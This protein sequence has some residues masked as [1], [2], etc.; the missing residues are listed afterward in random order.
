MDE[1]KCFKYFKHKK[2]W[3]KKLFW[4]NISTAEFYTQNKTKMFTL[5][6]F[7]AVKVGGKSFPSSQA[8]LFVL[9]FQG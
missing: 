1:R 3:R 9:Y 2:S 7:F 8:H 5:I 4:L 6:N